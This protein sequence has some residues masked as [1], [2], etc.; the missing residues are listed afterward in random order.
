MGRGRTPSTSETR[1]MLEVL[2]VPDRAVFIS[3]IAENVEIGK[4]RVRQICKN[5]LEPAGLIEV[6]KV[7]NRNLIRLTDSGHEQLAEQLRKAIV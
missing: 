5:D 4:E 7:S 6:K 3:E 1:I 2:L